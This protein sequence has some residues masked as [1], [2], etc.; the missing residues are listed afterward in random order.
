M[1]SAAKLDAQLYPIITSDSTDPTE[2][3]KFLTEKRDNVLRQIGEA[4][5]ELQQ[6]I[7]A[8]GALRPKDDET[9]AKITQVLDNLTAIRQKL[10]TVSTN[11][12]SLLT[13]LIRFMDDVRTTRTD[14]DQYFHEKLTSIKDDQVE[15][16]VR[17]HADF[18]ERIMDKFR[19]LIG[20]SERIIERVRDLEPEQA[21]EYDTDRILSLL[22]RL[23]IEFEAE[24]NEKSADLKKQHEISKFTRDLQD[25]HRSMDDVQRQLNETAA[26]GSES[27]AG[28]RTIALGFEYFERT[29]QVRG[30]FFYLNIK[31]LSKCH[32]CVCVCVWCIKI[33]QTNSAARHQLYGDDED[34][35]CV[36]SQT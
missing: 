8:T 28:A 12:K 16:V 19:A 9:R 24:N 26:D 6:R 22:E 21:K 29:T 7:D 13:E 23:R 33:V 3:A 11:Y 5:V 10:T 32:F 31:M 17:Q 20:H 34:G 25:I 18:K 35:G 36:P 1:N 27:V 4:T 2:L 14:I 30:F 15:A